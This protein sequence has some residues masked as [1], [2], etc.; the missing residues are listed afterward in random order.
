VN[1]YLK[2][3]NDGDDIKVTVVT[4]NSDNPF[5]IVYDNVKPRKAKP[6][7]TDSYV[8]AST[9]P[10]LDSTAAIINH[11]NQ[12]R[13]VIKKNGT[14]PRMLVAIMTD[15]LENASREYTLQ[16]IHDMITKKQKKGW[17]FAFLG[18]DQDAFAAGA[19]MGV[20]IGSTVTYTKGS[21]LHTLSNVAVA[22]VL[23]S[24]GEA[25]TGKLFED[26]DD[27][28]WVKESTTGRSTGV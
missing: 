16:Q 23:Y 5:K 17:E 28:N 21:E 6:F 2:G 18:A 8:P 27:P 3:L 25:Q 9:T 4:F 12:K 20:P 14:K 10:L 24:R 22:A 26:I 11:M 1:E 19:A 13:K 15:G 7:T